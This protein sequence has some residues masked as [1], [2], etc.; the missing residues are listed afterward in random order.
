MT[1]KYCS[2]CE[3]EWPIEWFSLNRASR[4][5]RQSL[6]KPCARTATRESERRN[7]SRVRDTKARWRDRHR[8]A[9]NARR[10]AGVSDPEPK[11]LVDSD[12]E[13]GNATSAEDRAR[14]AE[15]RRPGWRSCSAPPVEAQPP[16]VPNLDL[17]RQ[18]LEHEQQVERY[19]REARRKA[20]KGRP[21]PDRPGHTI[22]GSP[23]GGPW[24]CG[25]PFPC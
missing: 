22:G 25:E 10:R 23:P 11:P 1:K 14:A 21:D 13:L 6:C 20:R 4:D 19:V 17:E 8:D 3:K 15:R 12:G 24:L 9:L 18:R 16:A 5:G 2:G 7:A